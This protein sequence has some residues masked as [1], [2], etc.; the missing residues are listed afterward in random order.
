MAATGCPRTLC[1]CVCV[2]V[3][4]RLCRFLL[5]FVS[6]RCFVSPVQLGGGR[7]VWTTVCTCACVCGVFVALRCPSRST[8]ECS[9][10]VDYDGAVA[11]GYATSP[12][13]SAFRARI[14][15]T[16]KHVSVYAKLTCIQK[17]AYVRSRT[18]YT[19]TRTLFRPAKQRT[20]V[21]VKNSRTRA[22]KRP[23]CR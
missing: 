9:V 1:S 22:P 6:N 11:F 15:H 21:A 18:R 23:R 20:R 5:G 16:R 10:T 4:V 14:T 7:N 2:C 17:H 12:L 3:Q 19:E 13:C 8:F